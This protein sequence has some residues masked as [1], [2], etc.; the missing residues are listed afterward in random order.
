M[1]AS[2][3]RHIRDVALMGGYIFSGLTPPFGSNWSSAYKRQQKISET[4]SFALDTW[5]SGSMSRFGKGFKTTIQ[6]RLIHALVRR[7]LLRKNNWKL[8]EWGIPI[9]QTDMLASYTGPATLAWGAIAQGV[10]I[11]PSEQ[12]AVIHNS[13]LVGWLLGVKEEWIAHNTKDLITKMIHAYATHTIGDESSRIMA[14]SL[15]NEPLSREYAGNTW[16]RRRLD[17]TSHLSISNF[18]LP[19]KIR[20][21]LQ[22]KQVPPIKPLITVPSQFLWHTGQRIWPGGKM[23]LIKSGEENQRKL[24]SMYKSYSA[25][26]NAINADHAAS[27]TNN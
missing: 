12:T 2:A 1:G 8:D 17:Y 27:V 4:Y 5:G 23:R 3:P 25:L 19:K 21:K 6:V 9:N 20:R 16:L 18:Y 14:Q 7:N 11:T 26:A 22:I 10:P 24:D 13:A 15:I